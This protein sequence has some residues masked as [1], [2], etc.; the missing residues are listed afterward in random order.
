MTRMYLTLWRGTFGR[1]V[2][3]RK[4][5]YKGLY[6]H[7][8]NGTLAWSSTHA[9]T[10]A[11]LSDGLFYDVEKIKQGAMMEDCAQSIGF[12]IGQEMTQANIQRMLGLA[13]DNAP[14]WSG[15]TYQNKLMELRDQP[16]NAE[17]PYVA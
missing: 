2:Y 12:K 13:E 5:I 11:K 3:I 16:R 7:W 8:K 15:K 14:V 6:F 17:Y 9:D 4:C 1:R 10:M